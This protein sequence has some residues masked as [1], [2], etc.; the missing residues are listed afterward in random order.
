MTRETCTH[1]GIDD[2]ALNALYR[3]M[4]YDPW[5]ARREALRRWW[6]QWIEEHEGIMTVR[7][8]PKPFPEPRP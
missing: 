8:T 3:V 4:Q 5:L 2:A 6:M 1:L 7:Q